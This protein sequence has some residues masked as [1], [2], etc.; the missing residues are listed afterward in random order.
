MMRNIA[1]VLAL[2]I[3]VLL[4]ACAH[5]AA[6]SPT[7]VR[8]IGGVIRVSPQIAWSRVT[9]GDRE[10]WTVNGASLEAITFLTNVDGHQ[11]A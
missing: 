5:Y 2:S 10:V 8:E 7:E 4:T 9:E 6:V 3:L 11:Y 1:F